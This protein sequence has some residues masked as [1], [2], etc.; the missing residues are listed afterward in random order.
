MGAMITCGWYLTDLAGGGAEKVPLVIAPVM[1]TSQL[2]VV[3]LKDR[4]QHKISLGG[5]EI[6]KLSSGQKSLARAGAPILARATRSAA[7][8]DVLVA[9]LEFAPTFFTVA[10]GMLSRKPVVATVQI[11]LHCYHEFEPVSPI[12]WNGMKLALRR[13]AAVVAVS[14]GVRQSL[15]ELGVD[16]DQI[17]VIPNPGP[18]R[19]IAPT[20]RGGRPRLLTVASLRR[21]KGIDVALEAAANLSDLD[22]EW[23]FVGDGPER[24]VLHRK[25]NALGLS[26]RVRFVGFHPN[27][28]PFYGGSDLYVLPSRT[29]GA[30][31]VLVEAMTAG[32]PIVATRCAG[33]E[34]VVDADIGELVRNGDA[35]AMAASIRRLLRDSETRTRLGQAARERAREYEATNVAARYDR[36]LAAVVDSRARSCRATARG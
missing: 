4:I 6:I 12:W 5:P 18:A 32:L 20:S 35:E 34:D 22:F 10:T 11:D 25:A 31:L 29:E 17:H 7:R 28:E 30:P 21:R 27:P 2:S 23:T 24:D 36:L 15:L 14:A 1:R 19:Q 33:V 3:L 16:E 8:F 13:C 9:G 26:D